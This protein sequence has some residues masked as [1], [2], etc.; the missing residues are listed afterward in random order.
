[1]RRSDSIT[2]KALGVGVLALLISIP[3]AQVRDLLRER[4]GM[5]E[6]AI[7]QIAQRWGAP[8]TLGGAVLAVPMAVTVRDGKEARVEHRMRIVLADALDVRATLATERRSYG[9]Y[10]APVYT[11]QVRLGGR[12]R[13]AD[14]AALAPSGATARWSEA[15]LWL[16]I[17]DVHGIRALDAVRIDGVAREPQPD[18]AALGDLHVVAVPLSA[19]AAPSGVD[20]MPARDVAFEATFT[21]AG[22]RSL[23]VLPLARRTE[24]TIAGAWPDPG[25]AGAFLPAERR[26]E[27]DGFSARWQVLD[28]NRGFGQ[29]WW[30]GE[31]GGADLAGAAFGVDLVQPVDVYQQNERTGKYGI[32]FVAFTFV[33]FFLFEVLRRLRVHP[34][35]YL[36]IGLALATFYLVLL[37]LSEQIGFA[38]A[39]LAAALAVATLVGG[40]AGAVLRARRAGLLLGALMLLV[41]ALL[42]GL[43]VAERYSLLAGALALLA[44]V[45]LL[46]YLT[47][48]VDWY[49]Y[50]GAAATPAET[51]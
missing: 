17:A 29:R 46:M 48:R 34:V 21:L 14:L 24:A 6:Q 39:Y 44:A 27:A 50:G 11:A 23:R 7:A 33:A 43:V 35:Q 10:E 18:S 45:A 26:V 5:R 19:V 12:F 25:F 4:V 8:Q 38:R 42:Y 51:P 28:L 37:A 9:I 22:T 1:M 13:A 3:L 31:V 32:L 2:L 16:P 20:A 47:R 15:R 40:Y 49:R 36:L 30:A 41:Y